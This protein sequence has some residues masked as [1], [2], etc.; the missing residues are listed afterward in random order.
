MKRIVC[1]LCAV[2]SILTPALG[3]GASIAPSAAIQIVTPTPSAAPQGAHFSGEGLS[4]TLPLNFEILDEEARAGYDAAVQA[5]Y[6]DAARTLLAAQ[7]T[8]GSAVLCFSAYETDNDAPAAAR[9]AAQKILNS[10]LTV[11]DVQ[12]GSNSYSSFV[13]AISD[14]IYNLYYLKGAQQMLLISASGLTELEIE[15]MLSGLSF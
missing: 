7:K 10:T 8:D 3:E 6:P 15:T 2:L 9:E 4:V 11:G 12:Y 1:A 13:C 14:Q 5:D